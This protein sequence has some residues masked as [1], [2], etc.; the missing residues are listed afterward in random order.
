ML[1]HLLAEAR[2]AGMRRVSLETGTTDAF[3]PARAMYR[4]A[5]FVPC[6]PF[7]EYTDNPYSVCLTLAL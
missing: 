7:G 2:A 4:A 6:A 3:A 1:E 5:G